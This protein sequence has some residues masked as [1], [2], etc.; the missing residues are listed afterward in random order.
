MFVTVW[1]EE[2]V[3]EAAIISAL[4]SSDIALDVCGE[5]EYGEREDREG[6]RMSLPT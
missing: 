3:T 6:C 5:N 2:E 1:P 4:R